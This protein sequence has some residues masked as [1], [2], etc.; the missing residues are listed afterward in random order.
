MAVKPDDCVWHCVVD[1]EIDELSGIFGSDAQQYQKQ[2]TEAFGFITDTRW[3]KRRKAFG[4]S[5]LIV[6]SYL[7]AVLFIE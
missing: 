5:S 3:R 6:S 1:V 7:K 4:I 2:P